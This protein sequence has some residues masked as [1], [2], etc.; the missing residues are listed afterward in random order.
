MRYRD[1]VNAPSDQI[2]VTSN[3]G[4]GWR[5]GGSRAEH[6]EG[7]KEGISEAGD[8]EIDF[9][10]VAYDAFL[11]DCS[12]R[13]LVTPETSAFRGSLQVTFLSESVA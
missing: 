8:S 5:V 3:R 1:T 2:R 7:A 4:L 9:Y 13:L 10:R 11:Y 12:S 6:R